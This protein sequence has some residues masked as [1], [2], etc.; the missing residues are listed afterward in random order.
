[1]QILWQSLDLLPADGVDQGGLSSSVSA[2][3]TVLAAPGE[4]DG[5]V[6]QKLFGASNN[7]HAWAP[8]VL[9][10]VVG[11]V[12]DNAR[13]RDFLLGLK[14]AVDF[15]LDLSSF[16]L[17]SLLSLLQFLE[18]VRGHLFLFFLLLF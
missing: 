12:V 15:I 2:D 5:G 13:R 3:E 17:F 8:D 14:Q 7:G 16:L 11:F 1:M 6:H 4:L 9:D 18:L 10:I